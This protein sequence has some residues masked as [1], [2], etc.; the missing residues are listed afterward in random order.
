[1][2]SA[3]HYAT[4]G[5]LGRAAVG[6]TIR[7]TERPTESLLVMICQLSR[8]H[9]LMRSFCLQKKDYKWD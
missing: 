4:T 6:Y 3:P 2:R 5:M 7:E 9:F 1:M 8:P